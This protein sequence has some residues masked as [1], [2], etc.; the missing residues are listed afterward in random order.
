MPKTTIPA[1]KTGI[2]ELT[3]P[4]RNGG[5]LKRGNPGHKGGKGRLAEESRQEIRYLLKQRLL[6]EVRR[7]LGPKNI[8][9]L[10]DEMIVKYIDALGKYGIGTKHEHTGPDDG[11]LTHGVL[12][13]AA[14]PEES[15]LIGATEVMPVEVVDA[16]EPSS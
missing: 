8:K 14:P 1:K 4:G 11:P 10:P 9:K 6:P 13:I 5:R 2:G 16:E 15:G 7:R 3:N 12:V